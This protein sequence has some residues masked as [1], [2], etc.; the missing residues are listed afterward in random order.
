MT[1]EVSFVAIG[2]GDVGPAKAFYGG[3]LGWRFEDTPGGAVVEGAGVGAGIHGGD[4]G[5]RPY[6]FFRVDD[7]AAALERVVALGGTVEPSHD[8]GGDAAEVA[9]FG[10]FRLCRDDQGSG[11]G[12][13]QRP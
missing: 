1:G 9:R 11:F 6:V 12:L 8:G 13:H 2:V 7:L 10:R 4:A 5:A 3:L